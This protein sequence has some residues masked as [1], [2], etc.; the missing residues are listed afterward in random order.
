MLQERYIKEFGVPSYIITDN[1]SCFTSKLFAQFCKLLEIK[2]KLTT[3][4]HPQSNGL[5]ERQHRKI[6]DSIRCLGHLTLDWDV[7]TP[8]VQLTWNNSS[9]HHEIYSPNQLVFGQELTLPAELFTRNPNQNSDPPIN[10][11][12]RFIEA[13]FILQPKNPN[14]KSAPLKLFKFKDLDTTSAVFVRDYSKLHK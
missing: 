4:Y 8:I 9:V 12:E 13:M 14:S 10:D 2:H 7:L 1:G 3:P 11:I 5:L 6:K